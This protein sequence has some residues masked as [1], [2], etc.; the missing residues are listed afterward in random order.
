[1]RAGGLSLA[2]VTILAAMLAASALG[3][4]LP[5]GWGQRTG[6]AGMIAMFQ[7]PDRGAIS[8]EPIRRHPSTGWYIAL[9]VW[10]LVL[11]GA[12]A[13]RHHVARWKEVSPAK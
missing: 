8:W 2:I 4:I 3:G 12:V 6:Q 11:V 1:M 5:R 7:V 9:A 13:V 10:A